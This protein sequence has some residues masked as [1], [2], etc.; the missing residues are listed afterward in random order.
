MSYIKAIPSVL[1]KTANY[2]VSTNDGDNVQVNVDA[3]SGAATITFYAA[4]GNT[5]KIITV[6]KTDSSANAVTLDG[7][8]SETLDGATTATLTAQ[9]DSA[10]Y[11]CD[12][13]N[14]QK[15][16]AVSGVAVDDGLSQT[17]RGLT[18][19]TSPNADVAATTVTLDHADEITMQDGTRVADWDDLNAVITAS[20]AGGLDTGTEGASRWYEIHAI[21]KSSDGTKGL[22]LHRAKSYDLDQSQTTNTNPDDIRTSAT[23]QEHA[24]TFT[25]GLTGSMPF[26]D[27]WM[28]K[29][30]SPTGQVWLEIRATAAGV[31]TG[32]ALYTSDKL[33]VSVVSGSSQRIRF[34]FRTQPALVSGT[35]YA[36]V[37]NGNWTLSA[38]NTIQVRYNSAGGYAGGAKYYYNGSAWTVDGTRDL[39]FYTYITQNDTALTL[40]SG[41]DQYAQIGWVYNNSS[42][43]FNRFRAQDRDVVQT[44]LLLLSGGTATVPTL[45]DASAFVPPVPVMFSEFE[46]MT[47]VGGAYLT[48]YSGEGLSL[49]N[50]GGFFQQTAGYFNDITKLI[51]TITQ[52]LVYTISSGAATIY[53]KAYK[54]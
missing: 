47:S 25:A 9:Y 54:W 11:V 15:Q 30:G 52:S 4:S 8:A 42:S 43:N 33:D 31:P 5:G 18:L 1:S 14:W 24:Q 35:V 16:A 29:A 45:L 49:A 21:R 13:T 53:T 12:G 44:L 41:Y 34:P 36:L 48:L 39:V 50:D 51:P 32:A 6:K 22:L 3:T 27:M 38:V 26:A 20:G 10:T 28:N 23:N 7:N 46:I 17:F 37:L 19:S 40:P 2:T